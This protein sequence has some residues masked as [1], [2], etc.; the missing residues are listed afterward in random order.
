MNNLSLVMLA[1]TV[2]AM[3]FVAVPLWR[4]R[5]G[6]NVATATLLEQRRDS[7]RAVFAQRQLELNRELEQ[8]VVSAEDHA[9]LL[10]ELQRAFLRDM[11]ELATL[12]VQHGTRRSLLLPLLGVLLIPVFSALLY[13]QWGAAQDLALPELMRAVRSAADDAAQTSAMNHLAD[14]LQ[15]RF[16]RKPDD[17]QSAYTLGTLYLQVERYPEAAAVFERMAKGMAPSPDLAT[18]LGMW[19][20]AVYLVNEAQ[21]DDK[22]HNIMDQALA[23]NP[24]E[25]SVLN[26]LALDAL[27]RQDLVA[28][29]G[30]WQRQ[31]AASE[32]NSQQAQVLR[33][34]IS[35][36]REFLPADQQQDAQTAAAGAASIT[37]VID[38]DPQFKAQ[39]GEF[40]NLFVYVRN[41]AMG[42]PIVAQQVAVPDFPLTLT[43][44]DSMS[45]TGMTLGS[46]PELLAGARLSRSG[47]A[48][49]EAGDLQ[50]ESIPFT[51]SAQ[52]EPLSL[53]IDQIV[54]A[55]P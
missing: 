47:G 34:R 17:I 19:A 41:P 52:R 5:R 20:Q 30:Y 4:G 51:L 15:R 14:E 36:A 12:R 23:L 9:R 29:I 27:G 1:L 18:V 33:L 55:S 26:I 49:R 53:T 10:T 2:I 13:R 42:V 50:T 6:A 11:D 40:K 3:A 39:L 28:A 16:E 31:L 46:A 35:K 44:D 24:N 38:L 54:V 32:P 43:L 25:G 37:L 8:G 21:I 45:M 22:L 48:V 7:N